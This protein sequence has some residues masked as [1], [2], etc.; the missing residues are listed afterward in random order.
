MKTKLNL[1]CVCILLGL[2][3]STSMNISMGVQT[4]SAAYKAGYESAK[5]GRKEMPNY[6]M[7]C[8]LPSNILEETGK[9][10]NIKNSSQAPIIPFVSLI[11]VPKNNHPGWSATISGICSLVMIIAGI[12]CLIQFFKLI[13]NINRGD[14]FSWK[15]VKYLRKLGWALILLFLCTFFTI[16]IGNY[17]AAQVLELKGC[18]YSNI[19][20]FSDP[21]FI[22]GFISLLVAEVFARGLKLKEEQDLTI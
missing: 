22:L 1:L 12:F 8:T 3:L 11:E 21:S 4:F 9:V 10:T 16:V 13:R 6:K 14:I 7:V 17:E 2:L 15:N 5:Q 18:E 20:A 19:F